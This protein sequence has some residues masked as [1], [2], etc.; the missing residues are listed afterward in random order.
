M[1]ALHLFGKP[2][3][4]ASDE[5]A[6]IAAPFVLLRLG[7]VLLTLR[8]LAPLFAYSHTCPPGLRQLQQLWS[9]GDS[10][11][12]ERLLGYTIAA[13][14]LQL[15]II[16]VEVIG[17]L[18]AQR[19]AIMDERSRCCIKPLLY[20]H[21]LTLLAEVP[22][23]VIGIN[24]AFSDSN[25]ASAGSDAGTDVDHCASCLPA[26]RAAAGGS[27]AGGAISAEALDELYGSLES[28]AAALKLVTV[29]QAVISCLT[30]CKLRGLC[31]SPALDTSVSGLL[32]WW[33]DKLGS[34]RCLLDLESEVF[35]G[36]FVLLSDLTH[37]YLQGLT[38]VDFTRMDVAAGLV[39][40][41]QS[42]QHKLLH[43][44]SSA[45]SYTPKLHHAVSKQAPVGGQRDDHSDQ[46]DDDDDDDAPL[47]A[48][49]FAG[50]EAGS[51]SSVYAAFDGL[52]DDSSRAEPIPLV[53]KGGGQPLPG[54]GSG[55]TL[56][57]A[58][59]VAELQHCF[60]YAFGSYGWMLNAYV[61]GDPNFLCAPLALC[62]LAPCCPTARN[63]YPGA[64]PF[65]TRAPD[66][67]G[68]DRESDCCGCNQTALLQTV[69]FPS[70]VSRMRSP[71]LPGEPGG[72]QVVYSSWVDTT[73]LKPYTIVIDPVLR[74]VVVAVRGTLSIDDAITDVLAG[75]QDLSGT[76]ED[77]LGRALR[78]RS[79]DRSE[80]NSLTVPEYQTAKSEAFARGVSVLS[81]TNDAEF[82]AHQGILRS[83]LAILEHCDAHRTLLTLMTA[84]SEG[85]GTH[86]HDGNH[87]RGG[88]GPAS[89]ADY[90]II[91]TGHS[92]GAGIAQMLA[93]L[94]RAQLSAAGSPPSLRRAAKRIHCY[95]Y[96]PPGGMLS[97]GAAEK[98]RDYVTSFVVGDDM[99]SRLSVRTMQ[100]L[101]DHALELLCYT[102]ANKNSILGSACY[103]GVS[104]STACPCSSAKARARRVAKQG[105]QLIRSRMEDDAIDA[106][107]SSSPTCSG[108]GGEENEIEPQE[109]GAA[110][111][112]QRQQLIA[113][114]KLTYSRRMYI[115]GTTL[116]ATPRTER[117]ST[118]TVH[119]CCVRHRAFDAAWVTDENAFQEIRVSTAMLSHHFPDR[120]AMALD[121][122][123]SGCEP[124]PL[125]T[126]CSSWCSPRYGHQMAH[127]AILSQRYEDDE[128]EAAAA[129]AAADESIEIGTVLHTRNMLVQTPPSRSTSSATATATATATTTATFGVIPTSPP[130]LSP[131]QSVSDAGSPLP[132]DLE[133]SM[134]AGL[135][136][137]SPPTDDADNGH[138]T[139]RGGAGGGGGGGGAY[140]RI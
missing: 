10:C 134:E 116:H 55:C 35:E 19:G 76:F 33:T 72:P 83:A 110:W 12:I 108:T 37:E 123:A 52:P 45:K 42:Q 78:D 111:I 16:T 29:V 97:I 13:A 96:S 59:A 4:L 70:A 17:A 105:R 120:V 117:G 118:Y 68:Y 38:A 28:G 95:A 7:G 99:I 15:V 21:A 115:A 46:D 51:M 135:I 44:V 129:A 98:T 81:G 6:C 73:L 80:L 48:S 14:V 127:S 92:L 8:A 74:A 39:L 84:A 43:P 124:I 69:R 101:R 100:Q 67:V 128:E 103:R 112:A 107:D 140:T 57:Q 113:E 31:P 87:Q 102:P 40:V 125:S 106:S 119:G 34:F 94:L 63:L 27:A 86:A 88:P 65:G 82:V 90:R 41:G 60:R 133:S 130:A 22:A 49:G 77:M 91:T 36:H 71:D 30:L 131:S 47:I 89:C 104:C 85:G 64:G 58:T 114:S 138:S 66:A 121:S 24:F 3:G 122:V 54:A 137:V 75:E 109:G 53:P 32:D 79:G 61:H 132:A 136:P 9:I 20:L 1:P 62:K 18:V 50:S 2:W 5:F 11:P 56:S 26:D 126:C 93:M 25:I 139:G 23:A